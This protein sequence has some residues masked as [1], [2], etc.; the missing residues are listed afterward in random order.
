MDA[1]DL[2]AGL[3]ESLAAQAEAAAA[4]A[5][6][7]AVVRAIQ[8]SREAVQQSNLDALPLLPDSE[9]RKW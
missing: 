7:A 9:A 3:A 5:Q 6:N 2:D 1:S 8:E 4:A